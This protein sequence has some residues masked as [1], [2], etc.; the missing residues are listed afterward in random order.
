M[1]AETRDI[2]VWERLLGTQGHGLGNKSQRGWETAALL[3]SMQCYSGYTPV[4]ADCLPRN[5]VSARCSATAQ[6]IST[7]D[8]GGYRGQ[9]RVASESSV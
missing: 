9:R 5:S 8:S 7:A 4:G 1:T 3:L 6:G 2:V